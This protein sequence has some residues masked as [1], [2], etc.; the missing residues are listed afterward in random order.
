MLPRSV[1]FLI[2]ILGMGALL[3]AAFLW[4]QRRGGFTSPQACVDAYYRAVTARQEGQIWWD[5]LT[6][7][8]RQE[9]DRHWHQTRLYER[10]HDLKNWVHVGDP[11]ITHSQAQVEIDESHQSGRQRLRYRLKRDGGRWLIDAIEPPVPLPEHVPYG[12]HVKE[13]P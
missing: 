8:L 1:R 9:L 5:C 3:S 10:T 13:A 11:V 7:A 12:T 2:V 6:P 4:S